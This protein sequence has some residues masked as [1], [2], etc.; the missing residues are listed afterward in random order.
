MQGMTAYARLQAREF[1]HEKK[2]GYGAVKHQK[3]VGT[4]YFDRVATTIASGQISTCALPGSTEEAQF[5]NRTEDALVFEEAAPT[6][7]ELRAAV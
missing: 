6:L 4:G 3:F 7:S 5:E 1:E 2:H